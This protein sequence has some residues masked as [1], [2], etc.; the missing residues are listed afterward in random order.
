M[1]KNK[2]GLKMTVAAIALTTSSVVYSGDSYIA[3]S[4]GFMDY[5][6]AAEFEGSPLQ[7]DSSINALN[8][9]LGKSYTENFSAEIRLGLGLGDNALEVDDMAT[10][11]HLEMR[12][13]YGIYARG[14]MQLE[15]RFYP[16]VIVGYSQAKLEASAIGIEVDGDFGGISY[17]LGIDMDINS[18]VKASVEYMSYFDTVGI[19]VAGFSIGLSKLF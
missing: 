17:G 11:A 8:L 2:H 10:G 12:E 15:E 9:R 4:L 6:E 7:F 19:E 5:E 18:G 16:Y 14:G 13:I 1:F 3:A